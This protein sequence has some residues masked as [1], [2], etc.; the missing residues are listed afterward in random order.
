MERL[1]WKWSPQVQ[2]AGLEAVC[3]S[4]LQKAEGLRAQQALLQ[5]GLRRH[6]RGDS[7]NPDGPGEGSGPE[8]WKERGSLS[9][10]SPLA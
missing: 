10:D 4:A 7:T 2:L 3:L 1:V 8:A 9:P 6:T 5:R